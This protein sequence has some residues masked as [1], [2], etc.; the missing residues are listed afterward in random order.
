MSSSPL[1]DVDDARFADKRRSGRVTKRPSVYASSPTNGAK[2][3][4]DTED[5][6]DDVGSIDDASVEEG[7]GS[8]GE[9]DEE[10]LRDR[11]SKA[12]RAKSGPKKQPVTKKAK[13]NRAGVPTKLPIRAATGKAKI[14]KKAKPI[15]D[16]QEAGGL[17][18]EIFSGAHTLNDIAANWVSKFSDHESAAVAEIVNYVLRCAGCDLRVDEHDIEDPDGCTTKLEDLQDEFQARKITE[19]PLLAKGKGAVAFK[20]ALFGFFN[21]LVKNIAASEILFDNVELMENIEVWV[22]SLSSAS[23]RPFRHTSTVVALSIVTALC[24]VAREIVDS[25]A[26]TIR[27]SETEQKGRHTNKGRVRALQDKAKKESEKQD[28]VN[29]FI[30]DWFD[31][32]FVHR[33]RDVDAKI[34]VD[35]VDALGDWI[36][37]YPDHFFDSTHLR[38]LGWILSDSAAPVRLAVVKQLHRLYRDKDNV[39]GLKI[40]TERFRSRM[41][42]MGTKDAETQVR[43]SA[44]ELLDSLREVGLLEP[45]D[46]DTVG[47]LIFDTEP[48]VR[49]A[50]VGF[51]S[52]TINDLYQSKVDDLGGQEALDEALPSEGDNDYEHLRL[53]WLKLKCLVESLQSYD[54]FGQDL[55]SHI[56]QPASGNP[57]LLHMGGMQSRFSLAAQA[58]Y[59]AVPEVKDW[60]ILIGYLLYDHSTPETAGTPDDTASQLREACRLSEN[61]E[62]ILLEVLRVAVAQDLT[63]GVEAGIE[64]KLKKTK[65]QKEELLET[66]EVAARH[67][68][69]AIPQLLKKFGESPEAASPILCLQHVLNLEVFQ[70]LRQ[71][72]TTYSTLLDDINRQ[73]ST[74]ASEKV[75]AEASYALIHAKSFEEL[76]EVTES[77][78]AA[79]WEDTMNMFYVLVKSREKS[80]TVRGSLGEDVLQGIYNTVLRIHHLASASDCIEAFDA[81]PDDTISHGDQSLT[82]IKLLTHLVHRAVPSKDLQLD[83]DTDAL[84]DGIAIHAANAAFFYMIWKVRALTALLT[85][86]ARSSPNVDLDDLAQKRDNLILA[87]TL[88]LQHR[89]ATDDISLSMAGTLLDVYT[90]F[91]TMRQRLAQATRGN[92]NEALAA[93]A[94]D[95]PAS[96]QKLLLAAFSAAEKSYA[97]LAGKT[98][99]KSSKLQFNEEGDVVDADPMDEDPISEAESEDEEVDEADEEATQASQQRKASKLLQSLLAEQ[100]L[101]ELASKMVLATL[102]GSL[103]VGVVRKRLERNKSKLGH[104]YEK[105]LAFFDIDKPKKGNKPKKQ[106]QGN[107]AVKEKALSKPQGK[108]STEI[109]IDDDDD[110]SNE[111]GEEAGGA[112]NEDVDEEDEEALRRKGLTVDED[113]EPEERDPATIAAED[114]IESVL[115]D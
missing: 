5:H 59:D 58:L 3:K 25:T 15:K 82:G 60:K 14:S 26:K 36:V 80:L 93:L 104:N 106:A 62:I 6:A 44:V 41:V 1:S 28:K 77:K 66:Q 47:R 29:D 34:R 65:K 63:K 42:E 73:F 46:I 2:R 53:E 91:A 64:K 76:G 21:A 10:E 7:D 78:V 100:K 86:P 17:Y 75:L 45:D 69:V 54:S 48:R 55:P 113:E 27:Q 23:S 31:T 98:L 109:V 9:P 56:V 96:T 74:H 35:C 51:F 20:A 11:K 16:A 105:V 108:K 83:T 95:V 37:T 97:S 72:S 81:K 50:V 32:V 39:A 114:E 71:D 101:C 90:G 92:V 112:N 33:Y 70:E 38:Y 61:E 4:R 52:E 88:G 24:E 87:L 40:F 13:K 43:A 103:D 79:L 49:K 67:L 102:G 110:D 94:V 89:R 68:A 99:E 12:R 19:Y 84:E 8:D 85:K 107:S 18:A 22:S 111:E 115:G 30:K 57:Y